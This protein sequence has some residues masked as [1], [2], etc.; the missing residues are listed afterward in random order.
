[1]LCSKA[2]SATLQLEHSTR[3]LER[4][5]LQVALLQRPSAAEQRMKQLTSSETLVVSKAAAVDCEEEVNA[6]SLYEE[7][8]MASV[9]VDVKAASLGVDCQSDVSAASIQWVVRWR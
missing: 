1:M 6:A 8:E 5:E 2:Q 3:A 7:V 4:S 9:G